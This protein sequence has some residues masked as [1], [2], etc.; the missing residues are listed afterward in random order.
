MSGS[1]VHLSKS[2]PNPYGTSFWY[3]TLD[4]GIDGRGKG[5][6]KLQVD[7]KATK[8]GLFIAGE[9][10]PWEDLRHAESLVK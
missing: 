4:T 3:I 6:I 5:G 9:L 7:I 10:I 2:A 8:E 1:K